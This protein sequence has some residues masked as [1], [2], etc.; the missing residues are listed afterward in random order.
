MSSA[1]IVYALCFLI[2]TSSY[3]RAQRVPH[4]NGAL[5]I[6]VSTQNGDVRLPGATVTV[7]DARGLRVASGV[8]DGE[9]RC[10]IQNLA[11]GPYRVIGTLEGFQSTTVAV[12]VAGRP[13]SIAIDMPIVM[14]ATV[15][16]TPTPTAASAGAAIAMRETVDSRQNDE[17]AEGGAMRAALK[18]L[19]SVFTVPGGV[20]IKGG[21]PDQAAMQLGIA[22]LI[23]P[24]TGLVRLTL[25]PDAI[26]S[27][28]VLANPYAVEFGR[29]SSGVVVL[30]TRRG[31]D[32]WRA[33]LNNF[34]PGFRTKR[35]EDFHVIGLRVFAPR[36]EVGGPLIKNRLFLEQTAQY[37]YDA[38]EVPSRPQDELRVSRW[39]SSFTR[40]DGI[41]SPRHTF[42]ATGGLSPSRAE[43]ATLGTFTPPEASVNIRDRIRHVA[44]NERATWNDRLV[45]E[46]MFRVQT[47][48]T[49]IEPIGSQPM[50]LVP[51]TTLGHFFNQQSRRTATYQWIQT[52]TATRQGWGGRHLIKAGVD[53][54]H[55]QYNGRS[56]SR[57]VLIADSNRTLVRRLDFDAPALQHVAATDLAL[58]AQDRF[59]PTGRWYVELGGRVDRDG[60]LDRVNVTPRAGAG[61][62]VG[63]SGNGVLRGGYGLFYQRTPSVVGAFEQFDGFSETRFHADGMTAIAA[64]VYFAHR[65]NPDLRSARAAIWNLSY[66][67]RF[68]RRW[69]VHGSVLT[70]TGTHELIVEPVRSASGAALRLRGDGRSRYRDAELGVHFTQSTLLDVTA[71]YVR[72]SA[73]GDL[74]AI[75]TFFDAVRAPVIGSNAYAPLGVDIPHRLLVRGRLAP[76]ARWLFLA[77]ADWRTGAPYS[78]VDAALDFV[79]P[80]NSARF[81]ASFGLE[82]GVERRVKISRWDP[83]LGVRV[84]N[85]LNRFL[86]G[87]VQA[88][89]ASPAFG[90]FYNSEIRRLMLQFRFAR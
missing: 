32:R 7:E 84:F 43:Y 64:P 57:P 36:F 33:R 2:L 62:L 4:V 53:V 79:G 21:R 52:L 12:T 78:T 60:V 66:D 37:R 22:T 50:E 29:F 73:R 65:A 8:S 56:A 24:S 34:D 26:D 19:A 17:F 15:D 80:R 87:D 16:V 46:S 75:T 70:R 51:E 20:S 14:T 9:G 30:Q 82:L 13:A 61:V 10:T 81:P 85:A 49:D 69:S 90:T 58:F 1:R 77:V 18:L 59:E 86:P 39:L 74:N 67:Q 55:S 28:S 31:G 89:V 23:D 88:N 68:S 25:P 42:T 35:Y 38:N 5:E 3:V 71:T 44:V 76:T 63:E 45:S 41:L 40:L 72:S 27:V 47:L 83:W 54:L 48:N 6:L 11:D